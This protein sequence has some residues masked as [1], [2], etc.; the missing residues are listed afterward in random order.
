M[1]KTLH[2]GRQRDKR[3]VDRSV[4]KVKRRSRNSGKR[5]RR[6]VRRSVRQSR[7]VGGADDFVGSAVASA[8]GAAESAAS[9]VSGTLGDVQAGV[10]VDVT[11]AI[12]AIGGIQ[13]A[14]E[15]LQGKNE[16]RVAGGTLLIRVHYPGLCNPPMIPINLD[17]GP[18]Q[19]L[20]ILHLLFNSPGDVGDMYG[21][22]TQ[23]IH[24]KIS[25]EDTPAGSLEQKQLEIDEYVN[26]N[27]G[28][29]HVAEASAFTYP[30]LYRCGT[31]CMNLAGKTS[32]TRR[33]GRRAIV[34]C[35]NN[36]GMQV[37][38]CFSNE[39]MKSGVDREQPPGFDSK[40]AL[41]C[42]STSLKDIFAYDEANPVLKEK[43]NE[44]VK[45][46]TQEVTKSL[47]DT[48][49]MTDVE[50]QVAVRLANEISGEGTSLNKGKVFL[51][52]L[53][54]G[55]GVALTAISG[56][57]GAIAG[58][59]LQTGGVTAMSQPS[60]RNSPNESNLKSLDTEIRNVI[61]GGYPLKVGGSV[62][63]SKFSN[64]I[65]TAA[66]KLCVS[67]MRLYHK[68]AEFTTK[69]NQKFTD[70][71]REITSH[72]KLRE[73]IEGQAVHKDSHVF[74]AA[75]KLKIFEGTSPL[76][77]EAWKETM[78]YMMDE[79]V[80]ISVTVKSGLLPLIHET[81]SVTRYTP[82]ICLKSIRDA[83]EQARGLQIEFEVLARDRKS[84]G[85]IFGGRGVPDD[86]GW[87]RFKVNIPK[88]DLLSKLLGDLDDKLRYTV[89]KNCAGFK[90]TWFSISA[91]GS[92]D[93]DNKEMN[94]KLHESV[95][96]GVRSVQPAHKQTRFVRCYLD[97]N[98]SRDNPLLAPMTY[99][100]LLELS[101]Q[102]SFI[103]D[104]DGAEP[105]QGPD[106]PRESTHVGEGIDT[107]AAEVAKLAS[108]IGKSYGELGLMPMRR[109]CRVCCEPMTPMAPEDTSL[110]PQPMLEPQPQPV[111]AATQGEDLS[112]DRPKKYRYISGC[113][114]SSDNFLRMF[115][116]IYK[117]L[118]DISRNK[119]ILQGCNPA[120]VAFL[121]STQAERM[122]K[123]KHTQ[124]TQIFQEM[125]YLVEC[126][127]RI[128]HGTPSIKTP[129][130]VLEQE[131]IGFRAMI[132]KVVGLL[133][134]A[135]DGE[136][137]GGQLA[138]MLGRLK[139][140][141][142]RCV[143]YS[144]AISKI[145]NIAG[146]S[147]D[148]LQRTSSEGPSEGIGEQLAG[149]GEQLA[150]EIISVRKQVMEDTLFP[151]ERADEDGPTIKDVD[152][153]QLDSMVE[154]EAKAATATATATATEADAGTEAATEADAESGDE[155]GAGAATAVADPVES[156][157]A[158]QLEFRS[159]ERRLKDIYFSCGDPNTQT[160]IVKIIQEMQRTGK[161]PTTNVTLHDSSS[162]K[163]DLTEMASDLTEMASGILA[164]LSSS[165]SDSSSDQ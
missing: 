147:G 115:Q 53:A 104:L 77:F 68:G 12:G 125:D 7:M 39:R 137:E 37:D 84:R 146:P 130:A 31:S 135:I 76:S 36:T 56:P 131:R 91:S 93:I 79:N 15:G 151:E 46:L 165:I 57:I 142:M 96:K 112:R 67:K 82:L 17:H 92:V 10:E 143:C 103:S 69:N 47:A 45:Y 113:K 28:L 85:G 120:D 117:G 62:K 80:S 41:E 101:T 98:F 161:I 99:D 164:R 75:F 123:L 48:N 139:D 52:L 118:N 74:R 148:P 162:I 8:S 42:L 23:M 100:Q 87:V 19:D 126:I 32:M 3:R 94:R 66:A 155:A 35:D 38:V 133:T 95:S 153:E 4:R 144:M 90:D 18:G 121:G 33:D 5:T 127:V 21:D 114:A 122:D 72:H 55:V 138:G 1:A 6:K 150:R 152:F 81:E 134:Y 89:H 116:D 40:L 97:D 78:N 140:E 11:R 149:I 24:D 9:A 129:P 50:K 107:Q 154:T 124:Y 158:Y 58:A 65:G 34:T 26:N 22:F 49:N 2:R 13:G 29:L 128:V 61:L 109:S 145:D 88:Q 160:R 159:V 16:Q 141:L 111:E 106:L 64:W 163:S 71:D 108:T 14:I 59:M 63:L 25:P 157:A 83:L 119:T 30:T 73:L 51:A 44:G 70:V 136:G 43:M 86:C 110:E 60:I 105:G 102:I 156:G 20:T 54:V 27:I 132:L